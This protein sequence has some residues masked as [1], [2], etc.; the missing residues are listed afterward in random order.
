MLLTILCLSAAT[1]RAQIASV[2][3]DDGKRLFIN[4]E[5]QLNARKARPSGFSSVPPRHATMYLPSASPLWKGSSAQSAVVDPRDYDRIVHRAA[6]RHSVDPAL[7]RAVIKTES[8][9]NPW[10]VSRKGAVGL[11]QLIPGTAKRL[12]VTDVRDPEHNVDGGVHYLRLLLDRYNGNLDLAL[13]AYNA[14]EGAVDRARGVPA[15]RET[16]NYVQK[17]TEAYFRP[18]SGRLANWWSASRPIHKDTNERGRVV[19]TNE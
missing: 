17:V 5:G 4:A 19:F 1:T 12:G 10:V 2:V 11:M 16:R 9:W 13:A 3:N 6:E 15:F 8:N 14:G 7:V 18:G